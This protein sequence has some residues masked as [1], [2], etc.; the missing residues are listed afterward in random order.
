VVTAILLARVWWLQYRAHR[1][2]LRS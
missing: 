1:H 2:T